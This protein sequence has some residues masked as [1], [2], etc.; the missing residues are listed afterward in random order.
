MDQIVRRQREAHAVLGLS[1][2]ERRTLSDGFLNGG[3][4]GF[5]DVL[6]R[7]SDGFYGV[8]LRFSEGLYGVFIGFSEG[9]SY[10]PRGFKTIPRLAQK[11]LSLTQTGYIMFI[12]LWFIFLQ[13]KHVGVPGGHFLFSYA[14]RVDQL[15]CH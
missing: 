14:L 2:C 1:A 6:S 3:F 10:F 7:F 11:D 12:K 8:F 15:G 5:S 9:F 13:T 4:L